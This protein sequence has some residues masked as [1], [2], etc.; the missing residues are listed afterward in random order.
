M[1]SLCAIVY[2]IRMIFLC[3]SCGSNLSRLTYVSE[4]LIERIEE[5][6]K[7][8]N[9]SFLVFRVCFRLAHSSSA[10]LRD[11]EKFRK[12]FRSGVS[13][14]FG[15]SIQIEI[16]VVISVCALL[17]HRRIY[18]KVVRISPPSPR[19]PPFPLASPSRSSFFLLCVLK[20]QCTSRDR[21]GNTL[22][23]LFSR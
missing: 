14:L 18:L 22:A 7:E 17:C 6:E 11:E 5:N 3:L 10:S 13:F 9:P 16:D 23:V 1:R 20:E 21:K 12:Q 19:R 15:V 4:I 2:T 8:A